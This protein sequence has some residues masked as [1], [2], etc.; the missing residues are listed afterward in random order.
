MA[1]TKTG[2]GTWGLGRGTWGLG[3]WESG[4]IGPRGRRDMGRRD[5]R[6]WKRLYL[7]ELFTAVA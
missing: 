2:T 6:T 4:D 5:V 7:R 3:M 1:V